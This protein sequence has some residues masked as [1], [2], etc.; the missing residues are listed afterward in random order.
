MKNVSFFDSIPMNLSN[1]SVG[2]LLGVIG[3]SGLVPMFFSGADMSGV[4]LVLLS[5]IA[6]VITFPQTIV[7]TTM[8]RKLPR[9][10]GDYV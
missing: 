7:Y 8:T 1:M 3:I 10:G 5:V 2:A 9:T 6:F 4:N